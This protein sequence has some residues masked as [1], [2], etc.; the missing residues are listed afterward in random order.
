[1]Y[2]CRYLP[3]PVLLVLD[4]K[5]LE[6]TKRAAMLTTALQ[7]LFNKIP[8]VAIPPQLKPG[9]LIAKRFLP[10]IGYVGAAIAWSWSSVKSYNKGMEVHTQCHASYLHTMR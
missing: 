4:D 2:E 8:M 7:W 3:P 6:A 9:M 10:Y 1:M 5:S